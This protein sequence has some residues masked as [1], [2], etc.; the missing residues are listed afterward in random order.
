MFFRYVVQEA[1]F[2]DL[3]PSLD[4]NSPIKIRRRMREQRA[5]APAA[6]V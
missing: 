2:D 1:V 3:Y 5:C 6:A 4:S